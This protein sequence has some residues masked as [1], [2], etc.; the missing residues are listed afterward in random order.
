VNAERLTLEGESDEGY[1]V[2]V[3]FDGLKDGGSIRFCV[4]EPAFPPG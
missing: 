1:A 3:L 4:R 2:Q